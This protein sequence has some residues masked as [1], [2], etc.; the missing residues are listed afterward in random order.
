[1]SPIY[2]PRYSKV[3]RDEALQKD[4]ETSR[5]TG[6]MEYIK[7][8]VLL[9]L[10]LPIAATLAVQ[11]AGAHPDVSTASVLGTYLLQ[12]GLSVLLGLAALLLATKL[13]AGG[14]GPL[15]LAVL[16]VAGALAVFDVTYLLLGGNLQIT[17]FPGLVAIFIL[18]GLI[19]WL[20]DMDLFQGALVGIIICVAKLAVAI[21]TFFWFFEGP[22]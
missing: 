17:I 7:P 3:R 18:T 4:R 21:T 14:P 2:D 12:F 20:F 9:G 15:A 1:M 13:M 6:Q 5:S 22:I 11:G 19:V 16:R 10:G 8:L